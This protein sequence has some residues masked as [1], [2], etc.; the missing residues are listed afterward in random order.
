MP[1]ALG[2]RRSQLAWAGSIAMVAAVAA[3]AI[4]LV[5]TSDDAEDQAAP[6]GP[7]TTPSATATTP[8][9][10][11]GAENDEG[12]AAPSGLVTLPKPGGELEGYP[13][14]YPRTP[15][16]AAATAAAYA[17]AS[18]TLDYSDALLTMRAYV[19]GVDDEEIADALVTVN[20]QLM[21]IP[22]P[23][24]PPLGAE[25]RVEIEGI[26]WREIE[27]GEVVDVSTQFRGTLVSEDGSTEEVTSTGR[28][29]RMV[30][31]GNTW[32]LD[33]SNDGEGPDERYAEP[34]SA[35][36]VDAGWL[37]IRNEDWTNGR[38]G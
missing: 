19:T 26:K 2:E 34:G 13:I 1:N 28:A 30:W 10:G 21:D 17:R 5:I 7:G 18:A 38:L 32:R 23:G 16:G 35:E 37:I 11:G 12:S 6:P 36:F 25:Y 8:D 9:P 4:V 22:L 3:L 20:R 29:A 31:A 15:E 27:P 33:G 24:D 14:N